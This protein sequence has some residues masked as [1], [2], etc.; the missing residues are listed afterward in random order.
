MKL[1]KENP[2]VSAII[3]ALIAGA[4][5]FGVPHFFPK[6]AEVQAGEL[7]AEQ[8]ADQPK[9]TAT[10]Q[11]TDHNGTRQCD[12]IATDDSNVAQVKAWADRVG[13]KLRTFYHEKLDKDET[14]A[15]KEQT[16][17]VEEPILD[18]VAPIAAPATPK[19]AIH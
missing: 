4:L 1:I 6:S 12:I 2:I 9:G 18:Q 7:T 8:L 16:S 15:T 11:V 19:V 3:A 10:M 5:F 13:C 17:S 14:A